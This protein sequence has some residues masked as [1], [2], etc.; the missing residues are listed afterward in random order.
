MVIKALHL[1]ESREAVCR[2]TPPA[3]G[4]HLG[5]PG[6]HGVIINFGNIWYRISILEL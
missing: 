6:R 1:G 2:R 5:N 3:A 4:K